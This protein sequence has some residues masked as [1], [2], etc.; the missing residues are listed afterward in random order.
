MI[1]SAKLTKIIELLNHLVRAC[2]SYISV[3]V[4]PRKKPVTCPNLEQARSQGPLLPVHAEWEDPGKEI[5]L[6]ILFGSLSYS[7]TDFYDWSNMGYELLTKL[8]YCNRLNIVILNKN[9]FF[10]LYF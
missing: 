7:I 5:E 4:F 9:I 10:P 8:N 2:L 6:R 1:H 3:S